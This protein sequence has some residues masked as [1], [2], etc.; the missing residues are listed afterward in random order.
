MFQRLVQ[1]SKYTVGIT[2]NAATSLVGTMANSIANIDVTAVGN[3][4]IHNFGRT[5]NSVLRD[6]T[7]TYNV[8]TGQDNRA[9]RSAGGSGNGG[10]GQS[11]QQT[12][13]QTDHQTNQQTDQ[14]PDQWSETNQLIITDG[15]SV[16]DLLPPTISLVL[17]P[18]NLIVIKF[19]RVLVCI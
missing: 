2:A 15:N 17:S 12:D 13:H 14:Q 1:T 11:N 5:Y 9:S 10:R 19:V 3:P 8:L 16:D 6:L 18:S 4:V 7:S